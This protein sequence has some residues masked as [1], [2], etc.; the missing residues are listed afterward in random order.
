MILIPAFTFILKLG[1]KESRATSVFCILPMVC[2]SSAFYFKSSY[3]DFKVG[4]LCA[5]RG[6][7]WRFFR[8]KTSTKAF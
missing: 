6:S 1:E 8:S 7:Y 2:A 5:V 4:A 3:I